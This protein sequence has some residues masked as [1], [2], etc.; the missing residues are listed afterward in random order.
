M[1]CRMIPPAEDSRVGER[2]LERRMADVGACGAR[3]LPSRFL[4][5]LAQA[6]IGGEILHPREAVDLMDF[7][8]PHEA[9]DLADAGHG[10]QPIQGMGVMVFGSFEDGEFAIAQQLIVIGDERQIHFDALWHRWIGE[11]LGDP[12]S[13]GFVGNVLADGREGIRAVGLVDMGQ[14]F[15]AFAG[16]MHT[17]TQQVAGRTPRGGLDRGLRKHPAA[18]PD[19]DFRG[20]DRIVLGLA[21]REGRQVEGVPEDKRAPRFSTEVSP[22]GPR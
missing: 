11:A 13:V 1:P 14:E 17:S 6:A 8:Q 18:P 22:P 19:G 10:V 16:Q 20:V 21:A 5:A 9:K 15:A 7:V 4:G 2:P 12:V 3:A